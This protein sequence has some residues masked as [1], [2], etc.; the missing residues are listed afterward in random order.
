MIQ[1]N[2]IIKKETKPLE[3]FRQTK[4]SVCRRRMTHAIRQSTY[5]RDFV[6]LG[7]AEL[8]AQYLATAQTRADRR[9]RQNN[10]VTF[11]WE[12]SGDD[13]DSDQA[14]PTRPAPVPLAQ[15]PGPTSAPAA[16]DPP[17]A[18]HA[19]S[20]PPAPP[21]VAAAGSEGGHSV[22]ADLLSRVWTGRIFSAP[23]AP[24]ANHRP[25]ADVAA[26]PAALVYR[27]GVSAVAKEPKHSA[28]PADRP[29]RRSFHRS[30]YATYLAPCQPFACYGAAAPTKR[31][32]NVRAT[33]G[34]SP[35]ALVAGAQ[36][37]VLTLPPP[38]AVRDCVLS[39]GVLTLE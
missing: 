33:R 25:A 6:G 11:A 32:F 17:P 8:D 37:G 21:S 10:H 28:K 24:L 18:H 22:V 35:H 2:F 16:V 30:L 9:R 38:P 36:R 5:T 39:I 20:V 29:V 19:N 12:S 14:P 34:V 7:A 27:R 15:E 23:T 3:K 1:L 4:K 26:A 13:S 31:T